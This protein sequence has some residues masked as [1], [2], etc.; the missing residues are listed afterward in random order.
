MK[1]LKYIILVFIGLV[2]LIAC[3]P[4]HLEDNLPDS[5]VYFSRSGVVSAIVY[6]A[7]E[8]SE[9]SFYAVNAGYFGGQTDVVATM[10][11]SAIDKYNLEN[12]TTLEALPTDCYNII[13]QKGTIAD[14][15]NTCKFRVLF[16]NEKLKQLS[17]KEDYS[18]LQN[19]AIPFVL[20]SDGGIAVNEKLNT[21]LIRPDMRQVSVFINTSNEITVP[22]SE[23]K[24]ALTFEFNIAV[25]TDN[26]WETTFDILTGE[27]AAEY[28]NQ[29]LIKRGKLAAYSALIPISAN[30]YTVTIDETI[31]P[32]TSVSKVII[33]I[34]AAKVPEGFSSIALF[35]KEATVA[36]ES[37]PID[38]LQHMIV[39]FQNV[40]PV[41]SVGVVSVLDREKD[42]LY[43]GK[44]LQN[45]G[46]TVIPRTKWTFAPESY[47]NN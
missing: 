11:L 20:T 1:V 31:H 4:S 35:L 7:E 8:T 40:A 17:Q 32:G 47:Q 38:G 46:Y 21:L 14:D 13:E 6:D 33:T 22:R 39:N 18:D 24:D 19:Y 43:L 5:V 2:M 10:D 41:S 44:Y 34:D 45:Y 16:N 23:I 37:V 12:N 26:K 30:D 9:Y 42:A 15:R 36:G 27:S 28:V 29:N 25:S 3:E